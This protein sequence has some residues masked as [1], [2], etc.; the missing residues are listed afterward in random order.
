MNWSLERLIELSKIIEQV[1]EDL[2]V[3]TQV[4][5]TPEAKYST[6]VL[7]DFHYLYFNLH[8]WYRDPWRLGPD[9]SNSPLTKIATP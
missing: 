7:A 6:T 1:N 4:C 5:F 8:Y 2:R 3:Q 9:A